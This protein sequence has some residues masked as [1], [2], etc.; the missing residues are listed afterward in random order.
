MKSNRFGLCS[1]RGVLLFGLG[2]LAF[3]PRAHAA[4]TAEAP[5]SATIDVDG[6]GWWD[7]RQMK[8]AL[9]RLLGESRGPELRANA[10][11]DAVFLLMAALAD[12]GYLRPQVETK[13]TLQDG[14]KLDFNFDY[15]LKTLLPRPIKVV[16]LDL[17]VSEGVRYTLQKVSVAGGEA[18]IDPDKAR[19]FF[20]FGSGFLIGAGD[21]LYSPSKLKSSAGRLENELRHLGYA[22]ALVETEVSSI[23]HES[24]KV[25][26]D[27]KVTP[28]AR[29]VIM[30]IVPPAEIPAGVVLPSM[31]VGK[32]ET[33]DANW[34]QDRAQ[35][36]REA[37]FRG[38]YPDVRVRV[39]P[40]L[41]RLTTTTQAVRVEISA[42]SGVHVTIG[43]VKF[44]GD[45]KTK[46]GVLNRRVKVKPG[47]PL[48]PN[49]IDE[50]RYRLSR[51]GI[52]QRVDAE[53]VPADSAVRDVV[54]NLQE[55]PAREASLLMG[56]GSYEQLR[57]GFVLSQSNLW[58]A[59]HHSRL[60]FVQSMKGRNGNYTYTV[61]ELFGEQV[62]GS[63][64]LF[65]LQRDEVAFRREEYG[66]TV[67][68]RRP[69]G[70]IGAE[71]R[72]GYTYESLRSDFNE[73]STR[74]SD[75]EHTKV[76]SIDVSLSRDRRDN[77]LFPRRGYRWYSQAE[78]AAK[79]LGGEVN[80]QRFY[81]GG[82][83][84]T[85]MGRGRWLHVNLLHGVVLTL[86]ADD[87]KNLPVNKRFY[88]GGENS[89]RG[90]REGEASPRD[91]SGSLIGVK[92]YLLMNLE[93]EQALTKSWSAILFYDALGE[94]VSL[95]NY[96]FDDRLYSVGLGLRYRTLIGPVRLEY[97]HNL[98]RRPGDPSGTLHFSVGFP[99]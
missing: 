38:G 50:S 14:R 6:L 30:K 48:D 21:R 18:A 62:D 15:E 2:L 75:Q 42:I 58:G 97:G 22:E 20:G 35:S 91:A 44:T 83:Y 79:D 78:L 25:V 8:L 13:L 88:P 73:L 9:E 68:F 76:A 99:F 45:D 19:L 3:S 39:T 94:T 26:A 64:R 10:I 57:G 67:M 71:G 55:S 87:D 47:D 52:F 41:E 33:W 54:F 32:T 23:D 43:E 66:G 69:V 70:L 84:H 77:P 28:G 1:L 61:P 95:A 63:V 36:I 46:R 51:L 80:Y 29:W 82:S 7:D 12:D 16:A 60:Q 89:I 86:G 96:P 11:E 40:V 53:Y 17:K 24:G 37:Y 72:L 34:Q 90:Y 27:V 93:L 98:N 74:A 81:L 56:Y 85:S 92:S 59:A 49:K 65:G 5:S 31:K 4:E